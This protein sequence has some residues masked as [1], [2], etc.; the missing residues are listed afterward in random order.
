M[1][2]L[3][4]ISSSGRVLMVYCFAFVKFCEAI[5]YYKDYSAN[6]G[7]LKVD[8]CAKVSFFMCVLS[9]GFKFSFCTVPL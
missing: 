1:L 6:L 7:A 3:Q 8:V 5:N 2:F 4:E 9:V